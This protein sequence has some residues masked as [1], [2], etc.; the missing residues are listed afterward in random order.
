M[1]MKASTASGAGGQTAVALD[2]TNIRILAELRENGRI[3]MAALA[4]KV[5]VSRA[6]VYTRVVP[7]H[8]GSARCDAGHPGL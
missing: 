5:S 7:H 2:E 1:S 6:N 8:D 3:S 4:E